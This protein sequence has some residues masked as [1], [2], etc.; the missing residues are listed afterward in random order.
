MWEIPSSNKATERELVSI[1]G[2]GSKQK[3][4]LKRKCDLPPFGQARCALIDE[5]T[6]G[7]ELLQILI[8]VLVG[9]VD[10]T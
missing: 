1:G 10:D 3:R 6:V 7:K 5:A 9:N 4:D 8:I 2:K